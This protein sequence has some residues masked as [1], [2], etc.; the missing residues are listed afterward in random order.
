MIA[1]QLDPS[2]TPQLADFVIFF[3]GYMIGVLLWMMMVCTVIAWG[4]RFINPPL[5]RAI[6]LVCGLS[7]L[8]FGTQLAWTTITSLAS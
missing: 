6:N 8:L 2:S 4:R 1:A 3:V 7:L 5:F